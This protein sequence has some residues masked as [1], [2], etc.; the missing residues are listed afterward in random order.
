MAT[1]AMET[2]TWEQQKSCLDAYI[3]S[4][5]HIA[6]KQIFSESVAKEI[7]A[8]SITIAYMVDECPRGGY[9]IVL[10][11]PH[12]VLDVIPDK[13]RELHRFFREHSEAKLASLSMFW[14]DEELRG[15][16]HSV[17]IWLSLLSTLRNC[18]R[19][20]IVYAYNSADRQNM[21]LLR[22]VGRSTSLYKGSISDGIHGGVECVSM[23]NL[24]AHLFYLGA[25]QLRRS[26]GPKRD[27]R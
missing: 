24:D 11:P 17:A 7:F 27:T 12:A 15:P 21:R 1:R 25:I 9:S 23:A 18:G 19:D 5:A 6:N 22:R 26:Y 10:E 2:S 3:R 20:F 16:R 13:A 4:T 8:R 14:L